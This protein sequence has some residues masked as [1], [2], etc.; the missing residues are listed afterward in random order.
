[1]LEVKKH[2]GYRQ[3]AGRKTKYEKTTVMRVPDKY[4]E[5]IKQLIIH[6]DNT[7]GLNH[8][9]NESESEPVFLRS[10]QDKKQHITYVTK[11]FK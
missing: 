10:L 1:M 3:G 2:G 6:L 9:F 5:V 4:K 8:H 7:A 11:P